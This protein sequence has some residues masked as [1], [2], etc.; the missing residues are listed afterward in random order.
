MTTTRMRTGRPADT[1]ARQRLRIYGLP[2]LVRLAVLALAL[3]VA[4]PLLHAWL[5]GTA[6]AATWPSLRLLVLT[7]LVPAL[8][9]AFWQQWRHDRLAARPEYEA[10]LNH[11]A[12]QW[13]RAHDDFDRVKLD[14]EVPR[15]TVYLPGWRPRWLLVTNRRVLLFAASASERRLLSEWPRRAVV[16]A[17]PPQ[18]AP[19]GLQRPLWS[20]LVRAPNL[21]LCFTTGTTLRLHCASGATASRVAQLLM[22]SPAILED[23]DRAL[24]AAMQARA[25]R[26][27]WHE[28]LASLLFPGT[29]QW[30]QGRFATGAVL[31]SAAVLLAI[32]DWGPVLWALDGPGVEVSAL[33]VVSAALT[34]LLLALLAG[35]DAWQFSAK[36]R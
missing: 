9:A 24:V 18:Q 36:R 11:R 34:W 12:L 31:F 7:V 22:A 27:R 4:F 1:G 21:V 25:P 17:G 10:A 6:P 8:A 19:G 15:E 2:V 26:R 16:F 30:L 14:A 29:G 28:V 5:L 20:R 33:R 13:L 3:F 32:Y 23:E 35:S